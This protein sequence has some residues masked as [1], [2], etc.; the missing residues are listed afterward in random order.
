MGEAL[1]SFGIQRTV[2]LENGKCA[3]IECRKLFRSKEFLN[4]HF[5][6]MHSLEILALKQQME[7]KVERCDTI[8]DDHQSEIQSSVDPRE[9][10]NDSWLS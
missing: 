9:K 1:H 10:R 7:R 3:C 4:L 2:E 8:V 6:R 5:D